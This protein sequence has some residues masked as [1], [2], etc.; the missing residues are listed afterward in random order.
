[1][2]H[3]TMVVT[4]KMVARAA[5]VA[6]AM[7][8]LTATARVEQA[9]NS[10]VAE[11]F[12][13]FVVSDVGLVVGFGMALVTRW[14]MTPTGV[15]ETLVSAGRVEDKT[16]SAEELRSAAAVKLDAELE[17]VVSKRGSDEAE[18]SVPL[19]AVSLIDDGEEVDVVAASEV[20]LPPV[21]G[22]E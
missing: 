10:V 7:R 1:M 18:G 2:V 9:W 17:A 16:V 8:Q 5:R 19:V 21:V 13:D 11:L 20:A 15:L 12:V 6:M 3:R 22:A 14:G 4:M